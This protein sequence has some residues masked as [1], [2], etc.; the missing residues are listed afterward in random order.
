MSPTRLSNY[1]SG[2]GPARH[3]PKFKQVGPT[4][5]SNNTGLFGLGPDRAGRSECT[6]IIHSKPLHSPFGNL[7]TGL[8]CHPV[9]GGSAD[10]LPIPLAPS[11]A[12]VSSPQDH[13][14]PAAASAPGLTFPGWT[15]AHARAAASSAGSI[16]AL[17]T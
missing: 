10:L 16:H 4:R 2:R 14:S 12:L 3:D 17:P 15:E 6:P 13:C 7:A 11:S 5:N 9:L 1:R 8:R